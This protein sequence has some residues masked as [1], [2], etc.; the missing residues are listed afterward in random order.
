MAAERRGLPAVQLPTFTVPADLT[1]EHLHAGPDF[2]DAV[3]NKLGIALLEAPADWL[4]RLPP[5]LIRR[6]IESVPIRD[7]WQLRSPAFIK[8]PNDKS[9]K[10]MIYSDGTRLPGSDA[11]DADT[12]VLVSDLI[13]FTSEYR[14]FVLDGQV[15]AA[16]QYAEDGRLYIADV[17]ADALA[18]GKE[19]LAEVG[20]SLPSAVVIDIGDTSDGWAV[21]EANAAWASGCYHADPDRVLDVVLRAALPIGAL[22]DRDKPF[23]RNHATHR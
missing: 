12:L 22:L 16:S 17:S 11:V 2:A 15:H 19:L 9:I 10:A 4:A 14:L 8:S 21:I 6:R 5:L 13:D 1:A 7:A 18:F 3:A 20:A 23:L